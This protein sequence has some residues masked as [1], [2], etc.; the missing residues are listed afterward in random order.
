MKKG[1]GLKRALPPLSREQLEALPTGALL[2]RLE[3][4]RWCEESPDQCD[5]TEAQRESVSHLILFKTEEAW[6]RAHADLKEVLAT[7]EH[8]SSKQ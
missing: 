4:L 3:R 6:R 1:H 8:V 5:L 2:A 7:R